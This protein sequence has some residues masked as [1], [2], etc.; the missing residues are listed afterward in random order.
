M[1][2]IVMPTYNCENFIVQTIESVLLQTYSDFEILVV[3]DCSS[4]STV[5]LVKKIADSRIKLFINETNKGAAYSRNLAISK[6]KGDY[7]AFLDG[8]D[9]WEPTKLERQIS[10]MKNNN[11]DFSYTKYDEINED[12]TPR[13]IVLSGP[14]VV[15]HKRMKRMCYPGC[16]TVMYKRSVYPDLSIPDDIKKRNDYA[17]WLKLS[18]KADC[19]LLPDVLAH[20]RRRNNS[21]SSG[22]KSKLLKYHA[23]MFRKVMHYN[24]VH[25]WYRAFINVIFY[26]RKKRIYCS[27]Y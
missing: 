16:L 27:K 13:N 8:D 5:S 23:E 7:I 12:G 18:T 19:Y 9:L 26:Y 6:A 1:V 4:D 21:I 11:Y 25:S 15:T 17:L 22:K 20:Y 14:K 2:S 3:D 24:K 10:F